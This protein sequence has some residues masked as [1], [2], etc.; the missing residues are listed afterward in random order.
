MAVNPRDNTTNYFHP[1]ETNLLNAHK[2]M[3]YNVLGEPVLRTTLGPTASDAFGRFRVSQPFTLFDSVQRYQDNLTFATYTASGGTSTHDA[4]ASV[5]DMTVDGTDGSTVYRETKKVFPYQPGKSMLIMET[6]VMAAAKTG[7]RQRVGYYDFRDGFFLEQDDDDIYFV[8]RSNSSGS[9]V[10]TRIAKSEWN[11]TPLDG[12]GADNITLDLTVA[13]ILF[14]QIEWLGVGSVTMGF[15]IK[16][17]FIPC[18]R[19]DHSNEPGAVTTYM[20]TACLPIRYEIEN[21]AAT[22][23]SDTLKAICQTVISEGGY[24]LEGRPTAVGHSIVTPR[25]TVTAQN[26]LIIPMISIRLKAN[27][28]GAVVIPTNYSFAPITA[29]NYEIFIIQ[30]AVTSGGAWTSAGTTSSVEYNLTPTSYTNGRILDKGY[31]VATN[32]S[33][34]APSFSGFPFQYQLERNSFTSTRYEFVIAT[35]TTT[36][37]TSQA[38]SIGWEELT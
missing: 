18:H 6:F 2:A 22:S 33:S 17:K 26:G 24:Q 20:G 27:R 5:I 21:T 9:V 25:T 3:E 11:I 1:Q 29:A 19:F 7:L 32:Q 8:R 15:V 35:R 28:E 34:V 38:Y 13:Q 37:S 4:S 31:V 30:E 36:N 23:A 10:E 14:T 12:T 16:G